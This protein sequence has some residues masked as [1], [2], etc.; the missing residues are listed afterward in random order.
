M[1]LNLVK[2]WIWSPL[3]SCPSPIVED[4]QA[5]A[6]ANGCTPDQIAQV[7]AA[8]NE[9]YPQYDLPVCRQYCQRY[10]APFHGA[11]FAL[12]Y[13]EMDITHLAAAQKDSRLTI[14][15]AQADAVDPSLLDAYSSLLPSQPAKLAAVASAAA[16]PAT[17]GDLLQALSPL[18]IK[19]S[20]TD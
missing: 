11:G 18:H 5:C 9:L 6:T 8:A 7:M 3:E 2:R 16:A 4:W 17:L 12:V 15:N 20:A 13:C 14:F 19:F 10:D 1:L